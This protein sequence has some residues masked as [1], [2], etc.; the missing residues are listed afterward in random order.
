MVERMAKA[1]RAQ[2]YAYGPNRPMVVE[3]KYDAQ[4]SRGLHALTNG[5]EDAISRGCAV[6]V[7]GW[8][9]TPVLQ[10]TIDDIKLFRPTIFQQVVV[11]GMFVVVEHHGC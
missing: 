3:L 7:R 4:D 8:D 11:Q 1:P 9:P 6:L 5:I 10:F 2:E